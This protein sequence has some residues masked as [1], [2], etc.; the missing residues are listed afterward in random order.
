MTSPLSGSIARTVGNAFRSIFLDATLTRA[1]ATT[2]PDYDPTP[3]TPV[4]YA[5]KTIIEAYSDY[6]KANGLVDEKD[7]KV[8]ILAT[9]LSTRPKTAD[10][11]TVSGTTLTIQ[12]VSTDPA[13][14]VW[15][16]KGQIV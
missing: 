1:G 15:N 10:R 14:A 12:E 9:S 8:L 5:C 13:E 16:C 11:I 3:G 6:Y 2:G 7:R 4:T